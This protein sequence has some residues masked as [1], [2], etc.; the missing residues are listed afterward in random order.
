MNNYLSPLNLLLVALIV[1][2]GCSKSLQDATKP[3]PLSL[4]DIKAGFATPADSTRISA[5][6]YW[7]D[8]NISEQGVVKDLQAMQQLGIGRAFI[9]NIGLR[10][11]ETSYGDVKLLSN[12]WMKITRQA[13]KSASEKNVDIGMFN[14]PGWSQSGGPWVKPEEAMRYLAREEMRVEGPQKITQKFQESE[15]Y[16]QQVAVMAFPVAERDM[17]I[18]SEH[19][20]LITVTPAIENVKHL[21]DGNQETEAFFPDNLESGL[22]LEINIKVDEAFTAR[23]LVL[24]PAK[25][26][27]KADVELQLKQGDKYQTVRKFNFDRSNPALY[28]GF[29]PYSPVAV[30]FPVVQG[31]EFRVLISNVSK[32]GGFAEIVL[33]TAPRVERYVEKQLAKMFQTPLPLWQEYQWRSQPEPDK[34][35]LVLDPKG[36]I[37]LT[38]YVQEDGTLNW[39][40]PEGEWVIIRYGMKTTGVTNAPASPEGRGLEVDK[41]NKA[42]LQ[43]H[44]NSFI[45]R[46]LDSI[47]EE[48]RKAFKWVVADSYETGSQ[49]WTDGFAQDFQEQYNYD[50]LPWLP[51][52]SGRIVSSANE[53][54]RFLWDLRRLVADRVS[55]QYVGGL[56]EL[57][58]KH[59][60]KLWLEN[61]GHWGFP[62]EFLQY[63]GQADEVGGEF[64]NEG[65][66]GSIECKAASSAAHIYGMNKVSAESFTAGV[67]T[68]ERYPHL[69]KKRGDWSFTEGINNVLL[70]VYIH[71][72]YEDRN[73][74]VNTWFGTEFNRKNTWFEQAK[75]FVD[76]LRRC[77]FMLQLGNPVSDVAY[78]IGEDAPK[79]T[80]VRDPELPQ[81]YSY[82]YINAEVIKER[83]SVK[84]GKL[85]LPNGVSYSLLVLPPLKTMRPDLLGKIRDLVKQGATILGPAPS[86]S[87]SLQNYP[88][89]DNEVEKIAKELWQNIDGT[90][91]TSA[92]FGK[93][94]V[95]TGITLEQAMDQ[96]E[97]IPDFE[98]GSKSQ[99]LY[100]HRT[101]ADREVY[102]V[103]N[104]EEH[105]VSLSPKFRVTGK[106]PEFWDAVTGKSRILPQFKQ[107]KK[108][109]T[110]PL[111]LAP[112]QSGFIVFHKAAEPAAGREAK[113]FPEP[114]VVATIGGPWKVHFNTE[115]RGPE[116]PVEFDK[117]ISWI[118][119]EEESIKYYSGTAVYETTFTALASDLKHNLYLNLGKVGVMARIKL[120]GMEV[121]SMWTDPWRIDISEA[122]KVGKN[123]L[124]V[125]VVNTWVNRIIGDQKLPEGE[126]K[127]WMNFNPYNAGSQLQTAG[128]LGPVTLEVI[129]YAN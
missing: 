53:S 59:D 91:V 101:L 86:R 67:R 14:S 1:F 97:L 24:H 88:H 20:P 2:S 83:L 116:K 48:E 94:R 72:P 46:V 43:N 56:R 47:P 93:G 109:T 71:Q 23:A 102:F 44:F 19:S 80:G 126:R 96:I 16:F 49:N 104:Q 129:P 124:E 68:Y 108:S 128:L 110:V 118:A 6:W 73:P 55:Y 81:G 78:F 85:V 26:P 66:L 32:A 22:P 95:M 113:N 74:G 65:D 82:D 54:N 15:D 8:N 18:I 112:L 70:H 84:D 120:N 98:A 5:Y 51:V 87:P 31:K 106:Q 103:T 125:E 114:Q 119:H 34:K 40:V 33:S 122:I 92:T 60:L 36:V 4:S 29:E 58:H 77:M 37:N 39:N 30:S 99:V 69:L 42:P 79:M 41:M 107:D 111:K 100:A 28:V 25:V 115:E 61:Y 45:G 13:I 76:Y 10:G 17:K 63:G 27:F 9:G 89:A 35:S 127:T 62:G 117:L 11:G 12:K 21:I 121:G 7:I 123:M 64:W 90:T 105:A 57:A 38:K 52:L 3:P 75:S 50:P